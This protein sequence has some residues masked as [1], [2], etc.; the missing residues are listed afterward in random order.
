MS[1][2]HRPATAQPVRHSCC[3]TN[4]CRILNDNLIK[5]RQCWF[6][7]TTQTHYWQEEMLTSCVSHRGTQSQPE[8]LNKGSKVL[9]CLVF[10]VTKYFKV[11]M[12]PQS[13]VGVVSCRQ[14]S[15]SV[16]VAVTDVNSAL[17]S[18]TENSVKVRSSGICNLGRHLTKTPV[19]RP[20]VAIRNASVLEILNSKKQSLKL[21]WQYSLPTLWHPPTHITP[22]RKRWV[23]TSACATNECANQHGAKCISQTHRCE[24]SQSAKYWKS[25]LTLHPGS[26]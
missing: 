19:F 26:N 18:S 9:N 24:T 10:S 11:N 2:R 16:R 3:Q 5:S 25:R 6:G 21:P 7:R 20:T 8:F 22:T 15:R 23:R 12:K 17:K 14:V 1:K 4:G 13:G